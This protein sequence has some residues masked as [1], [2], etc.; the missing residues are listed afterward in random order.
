MLPR[1]PNISKFLKKASSAI[2]IIEVLGNQNAKFVGGC[3]RDAVLGKLAKDIDIAT[4]FKPNEVME[5]L[6]KAKIKTI[7]T[8]IK[9]GT[10]TALYKNQTFEITTLRKDVTT[11]GRHAEVSFTDSWQEDAKRRDFTI[12]ALYLDTKGN[13]FDYFNGL[14]DLKSKK[15]IFIGDAKTRS[16]EDNLRILRYFRFFQRFGGKVHTLGQWS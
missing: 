1:L 15:V 10:I 2:D 9:H 14:E 7:P 11:D 5:V 13:I 6:Q 8:G 4:C 3:V 12:N 16:E